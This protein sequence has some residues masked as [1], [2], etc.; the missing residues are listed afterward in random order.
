MKRFLLALVLAWLTTS[1]V[2]SQTTYT[3]NSANGSWAVSTN[4]TPA[5]ST[6][7]I[8]DI[9]M[10][11]G[12]VQA[13]PTVTNIPTE[14]IGSISFI[15]N[16]MA[17]LSTTVTN[18]ISIGH[19]SV[20][21][22]HLLVS[23]GSFVTVS[24]ASALT[25]SISTGFSG[26]IHGSVIFAD[27]A[28][29]LFSTDASSLNFKNGSQF[30]TNTGFTGNAFGT[31]NLNSVIF[32]SGST[33]NS[34]AGANPF[35]AAA[36]TSVVSFQTGSLYSHQQTALPSLSGRT[37]ANFELNVASFNGTMTGANP[38][39]CD[40]LTVTNVTGANF[41]LTGGI[42]ISGDLK[43]I[44]G[45]VAFSPTSS[46][47]ILFDGIVKQDI[48][49]SFTVNS[50]T[51][52]VIAKTA[53]AN[54]LSGLSTPD[55]VIVYG[56]LFANTQ[57]VSGDYFGLHPSA[58]AIATTGDVTLNSNAILNV[59]GAANF[60]PGT[61]ITGTGIPAGTYV[62]DGFGTTLR[63]SKF[64]TSTA[65]STTIT[66]STSIGTLG[67]GSANGITDAPTASGNIQTTTRSYQLDGKYE[68]NGSIAQVTGNGL[69]NNPL[70]GTLTIN[71][72]AGA[73]TSGVTLSQNTVV[74]GT[75]VLT[76]GNV[77]LNG[78]E[79]K[80]SAITG[81]GVPSATNN[82]FVTNAG[83]ILAMDVIGSG[84]VSFPIGPTADSLN[85][86]TI[87]DNS[88]SGNIFYVSVKQ[89]IND[90]PVAFPTYGINRT[91]YIRSSAVI[92]NSVDVV[93]QYAGTD[94]NPGV[95]QPVEMEL[96]QSDYTAWSIIA[97][98]AILIPAGTDPYTVATITDLTTNDDAPIP[99]ALGRSGGWILPIDC[100]ISTKAQ[101]INNTGIISWTVNSCA[102][103]NSFEVQRSVGNGEYQTIGTIRPGANE[104]NFNFT[105]PLLARGVNL[106]RIKVNGLTGATKYSN[107]VALIYD[108][109][110]LLITSVAPNPVHGSAILTLSAA[111]QGAA[112]FKVYNL[113]GSLVKQWHSSFAEG[114][115]AIEM[116]VAELPAGVYQ[117]LVTTPYART[118]T[119]FAKQ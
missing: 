91:W 47:T 102:D 66:P 35:G 1:Q 48:S 73:G 76:Q 65:S 7:A 114:N 108:S 16:V 10:F 14:T 99:Y 96:L 94:A 90:P 49:G 113:A 50:N 98:N 115:N 18:T 51:Q 24:G 81:A 31:A 44:A 101:K 92:A 118:V 23:S 63:I 84:A 83:G 69:P 60:L 3:W 5:R 100:I 87:T 13:A 40:T 86:L 26:Q 53:Y 36:P 46:N 12:L 119:R 106:Y 71:N 88:V 34:G 22:P 74:S 104:T 79:L 2:N 97:G 43:I 112:D 20:S 62:L 78:N 29:R 105:D 9:L 27:E 21:A 70:S 52:I 67:I 111:K 56:K 54:L 89:G 15:N 45:A 116:N 41:N 93:F 42:I 38:L 39:R 110:E 4:W 59:A 95:L 28:H 8:N 30:T 33:Y 109:D 57:T 61:E 32:E 80:I 17:N 103:V 68:Y 37:Y 85:T 19:G 11:D 55:S 25:L 72:S 77:T 75:F 64:A 117:L 107:I 82:H 6:P 58:G